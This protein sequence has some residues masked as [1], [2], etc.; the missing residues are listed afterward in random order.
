MPTPEDKWLFDTLMEI[1]QDVGELKAIKV[2]VADLKSDVGGIVQTVANI[3]TELAS[4]NIIRQAQQ[5]E[6]QSIN[7]R[8]DN[9][10]AKVNTILTTE[11][12]QV[13]QQ[14][15]VK[16]WFSS[17]RNKVL[18]AM[19]AAVLGIGANAAGSAIADKWK[20]GD[21]SLTPSASASPSPPK[22]MAKS[23]SD[24]SPSPSPEPAAALPATI[25]LD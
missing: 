5:T 7:T 20:G 18:A 1:K 6:L 13:R 8:V 15:A 21:V 10:D 14:L 19:G 12:P 2:D 11:L 17:N 25:D 3:R 22:V 23:P 4:A 24:A 16:Q 9:L